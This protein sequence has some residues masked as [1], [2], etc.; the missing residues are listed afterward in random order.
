MKINT[1]LICVFAILLANTFCKL[2]ESAEKKKKRVEKKQ[3]PQEGKNT[4]DPRDEG[5][6]A[7]AYNYDKLELPVGETVGNSVQTKSP[8]YVTA[9]DT[10]GSK[11]YPQEEAAKSKVSPIFINDKSGS[12]YYDGTSNLK[13][14]AENCEMY[15]GDET[16]CLAAGHCG[17]CDDDKTCVPGSKTGPLKSCKKFRYFANPE[18]EKN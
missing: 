16:S 13:A 7:V 5:V 12:E 14:R 17:I 15:N 4:D 3:K 10:K 18:M 2:A 11:Y 1:L 9:L 6:T 8:T